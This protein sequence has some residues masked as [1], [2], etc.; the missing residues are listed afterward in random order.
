MRLNNESKYQQLRFPV[1]GDSA[2]QLDGPA[3]P[4]EGE[5]GLYDG[6]DEPV[7]NTSSYGQQPVEEHTI[8]DLEDSNALSDGNAFEASQRVVAKPLN[9]P[10]SWNVSG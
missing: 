9:Q 2:N 7:L 8:H 4:I 6:C 10:C 1:V 3:V 5:T